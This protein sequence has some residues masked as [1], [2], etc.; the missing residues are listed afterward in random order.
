MVIVVA[1][2]RKLGE[3]STPLRPAVP[4]PLCEESRMKGTVADVPDARQPALRL[5][6]RLTRALA[7][8]GAWISDEEHT[9]PRARRRCSARGF[10]P[11]I[12]LGWAQPHGGLKAA[13]DALDR[14]GRAIG[15]L[16]ERHQRGEPPVPGAADAALAHVAGIDPWLGLRAAEFISARHEQARH[17]SPAA[18]ARVS[19]APRVRRLR[20]RDRRSHRG[21]AAR[22]GKLAA[23]DPDPEP[24]P[25]T[26][27]HTATIGGVP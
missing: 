13:V 3:V 7:R 18:T 6:R 20:P 23:G 4:N 12:A 1:E 19:R 9:R 26:T 24:E 8:R 16:L 2:T 17:A 27:R 5:R 15:D 22:I 11:R 10:R 25:P 21:V 14:C